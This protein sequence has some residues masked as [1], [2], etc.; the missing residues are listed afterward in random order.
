MVTNMYDCILKTVI[1]MIALDQ[2]NT[3]TKKRENL[4]VHKKM[5]RKPE[6][7]K[8]KTGNETVYTAYVAPSRPKK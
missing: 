4:H 8:R 7:M 6:K 1:C 3:F 2:D 5:K